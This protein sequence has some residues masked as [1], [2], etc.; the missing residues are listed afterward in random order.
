MIRIGIAGYGNIGRGV[1]KA[2]A[3]N[4]DM[5]LTLLLTRRDPASL[6]PATPGVE[7]RSMDEAAACKDKVDVLILCGGSA[8][9][10]PVQG[11]AMASL[12]HTVDSFDN[13]SIIP[14]YLASMD[15]AAKKGG[16]L[17]LISVGWDP[18]LFSTLRVLSGAALPN[19][20]DYTFWGT[21]VSQG[22]SDAIRRVPGVAAGIQYT[23]PIDSA[24]EAV[25]SGGQPAFTAREKHKRVCYVV[26]EEGADQEAIRH[27]IVTMPAYFAD[28]D[29]E[30]HF[31]TRDELSKN[32][33]KMPHGGF[34]FRSGS[35]GENKHL[36]EF[37]L[38]LESNPEFTGSVLAAG[39][40]AVYR[41]AK[42]G[43]TGAMTFIDV[44]PVLLH[45]L[46]RD[47]V[48]ASLV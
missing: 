42:S 2:V 20:A 8:T 46:E 29:T 18:G 13:H 28:Y 1:E 45:P 5:T 9:D 32:H 11:P 31:I 14:Q 15:G 47:Q 7:V 22:H 19:G 36:I 3:A 4:P 34:V 21:G 10:L 33:A 35:T 48:I 38:K 17:S 37:S 44:P 26:A 41:M 43:R 24:M 30:V 16:K 40:R 25:R 12:F 27:A 23:V 6:H 39:A